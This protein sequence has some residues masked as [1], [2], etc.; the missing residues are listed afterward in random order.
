VGYVDGETEDIA[1][2]TIFDRLNRHQLD[3][4]CNVQVVERGTDIPRVSCVQLC[5]AIGS[6][7]RFRQMVGRGSRV[8][9]DKEDCL[10]LDHGGNIQRHG[11]FEDDPS[12][13][14]DRSTKDA[15]EVGTRPT[16]ECPRCQAIY[17]GGKCRSCGYEPAA[18]E[19]AAQGLEFDGTELREVK[20]EEKVVTAKTAEQLMV[21]ALYMAGRS[22]R[23]WRQCCGIFNGMCQKQNTP[24]YK[25]PSA[26]EVAGHRYRMVRMG[27]ADG[28]RKVAQLYPFTARGGHGGEYL[29]ERVAA[30]PQ[31]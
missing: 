8:H 10:V 29:I 13:S 18:K 30:E 2:K 25:I 3:Y 26:I 17:R 19:R 31:W 9:P 15:G 23:T 4:L 16:I 22:G 7:V 5:V 14:L 12:W 1:R 20:R 24:G 21:S 28:G 6:I 11:F 27:S